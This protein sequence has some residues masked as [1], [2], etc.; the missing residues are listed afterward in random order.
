MFSKAR[1]KHLPAMVSDNKL[2]ILDSNKGDKCKFM[3]LWTR[4]GRNSFSDQE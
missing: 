1:V 2:I 3:E 4:D